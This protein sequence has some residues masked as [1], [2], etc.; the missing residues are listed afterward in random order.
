MLKISSARLRERGGA[1]GREGGLRGRDRGV[2][3][4]GGR[5]VD[6]AGLLPS[7]GL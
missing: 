2:D 1:P 4:L 5:E 7:A 6:L 3:L